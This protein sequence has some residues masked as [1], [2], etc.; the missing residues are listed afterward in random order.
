MCGRIAQKSAPEDYVE[1]LWPNARLI[2]DDVAGPRY[3]IPPGTRPLTMHRLVDQ[4]EALARLPWGY[5]PHGSRFFMVNAKLETIERHGWPW[6][7]MIGVGRILVPAD[8]W[9]EWRALDSGPKPAK[10]SY[11]IHGDAPLLFA[12]LSAWRRGA[13]LTRPTALPSS[14]TTPW[15]AWSTC[16]TGAR[17]RCRLSWPENGWTRQRQWPGQRRS[18]APA[19]PKRPFRG[20]QSGRKSDPVN[21]SCPML[22]TRYD[23]GYRAACCSYSA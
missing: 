20:T 5:K 22:S 2:F 17:W 14:R 1:I 12:G 19:C 9:Y 11:Y 6:K 3:N 10:Q 18:Y 13:E 7:L 16:T 23:G 21:T 4:A 8:G 15:A